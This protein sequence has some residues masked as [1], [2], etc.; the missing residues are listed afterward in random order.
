MPVDRVDIVLFVG[1][2]RKS[3][4]KVRFTVYNIG[5]QRDYKTLSFLAK[6]A[7]ECSRAAR[8]KPIRRETIEKEPLQKAI[9]LLK[10]G[11]RKQDCSDES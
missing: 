10:G 3:S 6:P 5:N 7:G 11:G 4:L 2:E 8:N 1:K 9:K